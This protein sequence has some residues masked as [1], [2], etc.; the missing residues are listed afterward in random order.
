VSGKSPA[1]DEEVSDG[2]LHR[3]VALPAAGRH[4]RSRTTGWAGKYLFSGFTSK[5]TVRS[6][7]ITRG[8]EQ[9]VEPAMQEMRK[10]RVRNAF[11]IADGLRVFAS[12]VMA[13]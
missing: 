1:P 9:S 11:C 2:D 7:L 13:G 12:A 5:S 6:Q 3:L 8:V 10:D 4:V